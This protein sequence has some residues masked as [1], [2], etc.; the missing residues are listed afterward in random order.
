MAQ[1]GKMCLGPWDSELASGLF[2]GC[3]LCNNWLYELL[4]KNENLFRLDNAL[5]LP[6][7]GLLNMLLYNILPQNALSQKLVPA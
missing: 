3:A 4:E 2:F 1:S 7:F 6:M 5:H